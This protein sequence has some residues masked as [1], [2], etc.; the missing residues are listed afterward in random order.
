MAVE[1]GAVHTGELGLAVHGHAAG[2]A[3]ADAVHHDGVEADGGVHAVGT[4]GVGHGGHHGHGTHGHHFKDVLVGFQAVAEQV[5]DQA[6][7]TVA[8]VVGGDEQLV[9]EAGQFLFEQEQ[10]LVAGADDAHDL[11]ADARMALGDVVHGGNAGT[12]AHADDGA[13]F[14]DVGGLAQGAANVQDL[15]AGLEVFKDGR[16]LAHDQIDDGDGAL[17]GIRI[18]D[19]QGDALARG[20][21]AQH[22][23]MTGPGVAGNGRRMQHQFAGLA[24]DE[25]FFFQ[26]GGWHDV[27]ALLLRDNG[28]CQLT[29]AFCRLQALRYE[30][31]NCEKRGVL[32]AWGMGTL[33]VCHAGWAGRRP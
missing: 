24:R 10:V 8:A 11:V 17:F 29:Q 20:A 32:W 7:V 23:E 6:L 2:A 22:D 26:N 31:R 14:L 16:T 3:H 27:P 28:K 15:V 18:G 5:G 30:M 12:A 1:F 13:L 21:H 4:G 19:G 25:A 33:D 9:H